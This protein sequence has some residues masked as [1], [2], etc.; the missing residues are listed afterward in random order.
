MS[1]CLTICA[2]K[3]PGLSDEEYRDYMVN[4]HAPLVQDLMEQYGIKRWTMVWYKHASSVVE[5]RFVGSKMRADRRTIHLRLA[6]K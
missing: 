5:T 3:K 6:P 4:I 2:Y 1:L